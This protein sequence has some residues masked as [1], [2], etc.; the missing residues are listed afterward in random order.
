MGHCFSRRS[1]VTPVP[2]GSMPRTLYVVAPMTRFVPCTAPA[3]SAV[4]IVAQRLRIGSVE[5]HAHGHPTERR[6]DREVVGIEERRQVFDEG[7]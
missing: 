1:S 3:A 5:D 7:H 6:V 2:S 4:A